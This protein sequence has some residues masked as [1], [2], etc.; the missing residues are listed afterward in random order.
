[1]RVFSGVQ[2]SGSLHIGNYIGAISQFV[3]LQS[4][5]ECLFCVVDLHALTVPR[6]PA[7]LREETLRVAALYL[8]CGIDPSQAVVFIQSQVPAHAELAWL[9]G[10]STTFGE[11][12]RMTQFKD[13]AERGGRA[14]PSLGLFAY[15]VLM[16]ADILLYRATAVPVGD[17]QKQHLELTRDLAARFNARFGDTFPLP[18]PLIGPVGARVMS[19]QNPAEKMSKSNPDPASRIELLDSPEAIAAKIRRAVTDSG[20]EVRHDPQ[21]KPAVSNLLEIFSALSGEPIAALEA[22]YGDA[23]YGKFKADLAEAVAQALEPIRRRYAAITAEPARLQAMLAEGAER[24]RRL[25]APT[26]AEV[27]RR[28]GLLPSEG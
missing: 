28:L 1:V 12:R 15:P 11:L 9:L 10:C 21:A 16:A 23:G 13:K 2:P 7:A 8:A 26:L 17:D 3:R 18:E 6:E 27:R 4:Q 19:L 20:R 24:A 14:G 22:R 5:A 25:A